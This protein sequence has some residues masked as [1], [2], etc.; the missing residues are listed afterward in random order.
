MKKNAIFALL[1][2]G[3][4]TMQNSFAFCFEDA[5]NRLPRIVGPSEVKDYVFS[6]FNAQP[7][8]QAKS[9]LNYLCPLYLLNQAKANP[10]RA[11]LVVGA[12][13]TSAAFIAMYDDNKSFIDNLVNFPSQLWIKF[14]NVIACLQSKKSA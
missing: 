9:A 4:V 8:E 3:A 6:F 7:E 5:Y 14:N 10:A 11:A 1:L 13:A 2:V 12:I